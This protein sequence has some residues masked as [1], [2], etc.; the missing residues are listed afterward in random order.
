MKIAI[1]PSGRASAGPGQDP[2]DNVRPGEPQPLRVLGAANT[3]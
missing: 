1:I 3:G 2:A